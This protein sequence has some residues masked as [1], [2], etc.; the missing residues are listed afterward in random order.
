MEVQFRDELYKKYSVLKE[1][2]ILKEKYNVIIEKLKFASSISCS[3]SHHKHYLLC[4]NEILQCQDVEKLIR[5][6]ESATDPPKYFVIIEDTFVIVKHAHIATGHGD[7][8]RII[9]ELSKKWCTEKFPS[10]RFPPR[11]VPT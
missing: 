5:K 3:R 10:K 7:C 4:R 11:K 2:L 1:V 8:D 9:K 6:R